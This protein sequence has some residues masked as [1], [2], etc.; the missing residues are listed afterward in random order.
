MAKIE[1]VQKDKQRSTKHTYKTLFVLF[2]LGIVLSV[3]RYAI[4]DYPFGIFK[5]FMTSQNGQL[6]QYLMVVHE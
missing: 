6:I 2:L 4:F 1:N 5:L 3:L